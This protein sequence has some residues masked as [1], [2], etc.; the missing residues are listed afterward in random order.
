MGVY[1]LIRANNYY[2]QI[3]N[4][5][6]IESCMEIKYDDNVSALVVYHKVLG[7]YIQFT[8]LSG[9]QL[10]ANVGLSW[11]DGADLDAPS[12]LITES[13]SG[14]AYNGGG[15]MVINND[16]FA[17]GQYYNT[18]YSNCMILFE[19]NGD[20]MALGLNGSGTNYS[21]TYPHNISTGEPIRTLRFT[22]SKTPYPTISGNYTS[23]DTYYYHNDPILA[24]TF[25]KSTKAKYLYRPSNYMVP[26]EGIGTTL[27]LNGYYEGAYDMYTMCL[28]FEGMYY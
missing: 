12:Y 1:N 21:Q 23:H 15:G 13:R 28:I 17:I 26:I 19:D 5:C 4:A 25:T 9:P 11:T 22:P 27:I 3:K 16:C 24:L 10:L 18:T 20:V 8:N 6:E 14:S 2:A 7:V